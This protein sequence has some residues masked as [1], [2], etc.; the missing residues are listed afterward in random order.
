MLDDANQLRIIKAIDKKLIILYFVNKD[1]FQV[2]MN[3]LTTRYYHNIM[4][5][6][7]TF[8]ITIYVLMQNTLVHKCYKLNMINM[9]SCWS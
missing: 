8:L 9:S 1:I 6:L 3:I 4:I 5:S 7:F 2:H